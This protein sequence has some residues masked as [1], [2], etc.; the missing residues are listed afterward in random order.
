MRLGA[1]GNGSQRVT[2]RTADA[3][4][5]ASVVTQMRLNLVN[6]SPAWKN[7]QESVSV[8]RATGG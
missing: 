4:K 1:V 7:L 2:A 6:L 3:R 8:N 5:R